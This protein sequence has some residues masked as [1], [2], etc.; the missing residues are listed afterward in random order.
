MKVPKI[1]ESYKSKALTFI[2]DKK[3]KEIIFSEN[4]YE[5]EVIDEKAE[6]SPFWPFL[7]VDDEGNITDFFC[8]CSESEINGG[9]V[10]LTAA[11]MRICDD[12]GVPL[13]VRFRNSLWNGLCHIASLTLGYDAKVLKK[14]DK[15]KYYC[16]SKTGKLI[17]KIDGKVAKAIKHIEDNFVKRKDETE[18]TSLKFSNLSLDEISKWREGKASTHLRYE[19]SFWS[20]IAKWLF[21]MQDE[22]DEYNIKF[23]NSVSP[24]PHKIIAN[25]KTVQIECYIAENHWL[26]IIPLLA[27]VDSPLGVF[28]YEDQIID[29]IE[30]NEEEK[31]FVITKKE[32]GI[33]LD[34]KKKYTTVD[35]WLY[36]PNVGFYSYNPTPILEKPFINKD[37]VEE[38]LNNY[39]KILRQF[40][41]NA[42]I[43]NNVVEVQ[44]NLSFDGEDNFH[45]DTYIFDKGDMD[46]DRSSIFDGW[47][48]IHNKKGWYRLE[49]K[50]F[51]EKNKVIHKSKVS[52]FINNNRVWLQQYD[53]FNINFSSI[54]AKLTYSLT[55]NALL[56]DTNLDFPVGVDSYKDFGEWV[57]AA[58][59]GFYIKKAAKSLLPLKAG[60][61]VDVKEL[62][63][64]IDSYQEELEQV[65][66]FFTSNGPIDKIGLNIFLDDKGNITI[67]P[68]TILK[69]EVKAEDLIFFDN[70]IYIKGDGF[71]ILPQELK[72]PKKYS[73]KIVVA[74]TNESFFVKYELDKLKRFAL[75]I[76]N[77]LVKPKFLTLVIK[78]ITKEKKKRGKY[79]LLDLQYKSELG[80]VSVTDLFHEVNKKKDFA[81]TEAGLINLQLL[82]FSWITYLHKNNLHRTKKLVRLNMLEWIRLSVFERVQ[83]PK[84]EGKEAKRI[85]KLFFEMQNFSSDEIIHCDSLKATLRPYQ[86]TGTHWLWFLYCHNLSGLLCDEMGL[87]KTH[88]AMAL[89]AA[90][91]HDDTN[92]ENKYLVVC[93]T[94]VIYHWEESLKE[95][96][97]HLRVCVFHGFSRHIDKFEKEY[98][99]LLTSYGIVRME[100]ERINKWHYALAVFDEIQI[101]K[102]YASKTNKA[103]KVIDAKM[104]LGLT[105]TPI[106]NYIIELKAL[107]DVVLPHYLPSDKVFK[108]LFINP[109]EKERD[110]EKQNLLSRLIK[111]F[112][113]RRKKA[114]VLKDLPE[115]IEEI[116]YCDMSSEQVI[117][118]NDILSLTKKEFM[119]ELNKSDK[120]IPYVHIFALLSKL[121]QVC[122]HPSLILKDTRSYNKHE[123][124]KW[125]LFKE[126][127]QEARESN[128]KVVVFSQYLGMISII[129]SYLK[130][131]KIGYALIKG[132]TKKRAEE[133]K[134]FCDDPNCEVFVASLLAA[135]VGINLTVASVVIHY[136]RWWNPAKEN[137]A[138]D[139]VHRIGQT[140]GVQVFKL[141]SKNTIEERI[142]QLI[143]NK[144][145]LIEDTLG[146]DDSEEI[147]QLSREEILAVLQ[148][149]S[150]TSEL[151]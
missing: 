19:L 47:V 60:L 12:E 58:N 139:R 89:M 59:K 57:Y 35:K 11:F 128:Q 16:S 49:G 136:D 22:G 29:K 72:L 56:F 146:K 88:Q 27:S 15:G 96:L 143:E 104:K 45:I 131:K 149:I 141:V 44:Y 118:Y 43:Y 6:G 135:G 74:K 17:F 116:A 66:G 86:E 69:K 26:K 71:F 68:K 122:D 77:K 115:K 106:E 91:S 9:C 64:F 78:N 92:R 63:Q 151:E 62:S 39:T 3:V 111:P 119:T 90:I 127:L 75:Q 138:T 121:K 5:V 147:K 70:Y 112:I 130:R 51:N 34:D 113:L 76:D 14:K 102:N 80:E 107:F 52:D 108:S 61:S 109:I 41:R 137:Q 124:G 82:N 38:V 120:P 50:L 7:Q 65:D 87:G 103:L 54:Q 132:A 97:P 117:M 42:T 140:R 18:E 101:A 40:L 81:F 148:E 125:E 144:K 84:G 93:P 13:H 142:H 145:G 31:G 33:N 129:E 10:H 114:E 73:N 100:Q 1:F 21:L 23:V 28:D 98:D 32:E 123:S 83:E 95:F 30:Y 133:I 105:G 67:E 24:L 36:V 20:D 110:K 94:S 4:T 126:L 46:N 134:R 37:S 150:L 85:Q 53:G 55:D 99:V 48:Y 79:F 8:T 2:K 25:F